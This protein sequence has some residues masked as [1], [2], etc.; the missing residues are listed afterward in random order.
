MQAGGRRLALL[1]GVASVLL[2]A[3]VPLF[4]RRQQP[5]DQG[6]RARAIVRSMREGE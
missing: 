1:L 6:A 3:A 4:T 5:A 2:S